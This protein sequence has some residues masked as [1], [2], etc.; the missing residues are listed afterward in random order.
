[1]EV[2]GK[3]KGSATANDIYN[4]EMLYSCVMCLLSVGL[5]SLEDLFFYKLSS[6]G[7]P[8]FTVR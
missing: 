8:M 6:V 7:K 4:T 1:M 3:K 5:I 2:K